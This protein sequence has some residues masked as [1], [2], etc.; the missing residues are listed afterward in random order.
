MEKEDKAAIIDI[1][2]SS[3]KEKKPIPTIGELTDEKLET[4]N[5]KEE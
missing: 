3:V 1:G 4:D 5:N 2:Y